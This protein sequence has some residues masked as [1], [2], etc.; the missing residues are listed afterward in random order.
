MPTVVEN[1]GAAERTLSAGQL[2]DICPLS[3]EATRQLDDT[4]TADVFL[5]MLIERE[6]YSDAIRFTAYKLD[7]RDAIWWAT[8]CL[9]DNQR[10]TT[11]PEVDAVFQAIVQWLQSPNDTGRRAVEAAS[12]EVGLNS[13]LGMLGQAVYFSEGSISLPDCPEVSPEPYATAKQVASAVLLASKKAKRPDYTA[14][15][16]QRRYLVLAAAVE[17]GQLPWS[18]NAVSNRYEKKSEDETLLTG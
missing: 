8:L 14:A 9:W 4:Q 15:D 10:Q 12:R 7:K 1:A 16:I 17:Q 18:S 2:A 13:P 11:A 3:A 5:A 6:L